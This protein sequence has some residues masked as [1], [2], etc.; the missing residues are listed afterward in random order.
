MFLCWC[1][2]LDVTILFLQYEKLRV[3][4]MILACR[5]LA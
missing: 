4:G 3:V 1:Y 2:H 5:V